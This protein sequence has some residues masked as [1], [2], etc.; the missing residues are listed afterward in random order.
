MA[1]E[2]G[3][4]IERRIDGVRRDLLEAVMSNEPVT[5]VKAPPGSGKTRL[6]LDAAGLLLSEKLRVAIAAQTNSQADD[7]CERFV[8]DFGESVV[9][10]HSASG[11]PPSGLPERVQLASKPADIPAGPVVVVGTS[12]KWG[13]SG[14]PFEGFD[15]LLIDEAWQLSFADFRLMHEVAPRF[16]MVGDP[17]QILPVVTIDTSRWEPADEP[18]HRP[19]PQIIIEQR[20]KTRPLVLELP[21]TWRLPPDSAQVVREFYDFAFDS[22][23][24]PGE[25]GLTVGD[26][27]GS[28]NYDDAIDLLESGSMAGVTLPTPD[29]GPPLEED[30]EL[31]QAAAGIVERLLDSDITIRIDGKERALEPADI[32]MVASHRVMNTRMREAL[33]P[34]VAAEMMVDTAERWQGLQRPVMIAVHPVSGVTDPG[35]FDLETQ[36]LCVMASRH[37]IGLIIVTRDH[38]ANTLQELTPSATQHPGRPDAFGDGLEKH[39]KFWKDLESSGRVVGL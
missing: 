29:E 32:G 35:V 37:Q 12:A 39:E 18:P 34:D 19:A 38:L 13:L 6:T 16:V 36:R 25:R 14:M 20:E 3:S 5:I 28:S 27:P 30:L 22:A 26:R 2:M 8:E 10:F 31:A 1:P 15:W 4:D 33:S 23:V 7:I 9:R 11:L 17:G 21:A 24:E